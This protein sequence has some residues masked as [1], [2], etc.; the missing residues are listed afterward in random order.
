MPLEEVA[1]AI[2]D[3]ARGQRIKILKKKKKEKLTTA[4]NF[5]SKFI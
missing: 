3:A 2:L 4:Q 1:A 5:S